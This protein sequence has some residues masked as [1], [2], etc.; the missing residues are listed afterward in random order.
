MNKGKLIRLRGLFTKFMQQ[1]IILVCW[2]FPWQESR[3]STF[4]TVKKKLR[5]KKTNP[6]VIW[7]RVRA[8]FATFWRDFSRPGRTKAWLRGKEIDASNNRCGLPWVAIPPRPDI[9]HVSQLENPFMLLKIQEHSRLITA[10]RRSL[11]A[12]ICSAVG[13]VCIFLSVTVC[14]FEK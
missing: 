5:K 1:D 12:M 11:K 6:D 9:H 13:R 8:P 3:W 14:Q 7:G 10:L 2:P 4:C